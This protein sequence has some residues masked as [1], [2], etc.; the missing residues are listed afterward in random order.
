MTATLIDVIGVLVLAYNTLR[1][2]STGLIRTSV[3]MMAVILASYYAW[4][5]PDLG[6]HL[7]YG[8]VPPTMPLAFLARPFAVW[9]LVFG[10]VNLAGVL[11]RFMVRVTSLVMADRIGGALFGLMTGLVI[12]ITPMLLLASFPLLQQI[13]LIQQTLAQ[14]LLAN[15]L[16]PMVQELQHFAPAFPL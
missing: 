15:A 6:R 16:T 3:G 13:P 14:S 12:L 8:W 9:V 10:V 1:G 2:L 4:Q 11:L 7:A 5:Y